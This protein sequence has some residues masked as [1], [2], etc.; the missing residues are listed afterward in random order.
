MS[1]SDLRQSLASVLEGWRVGEGLSKKDA[2]ARLGV[3]P[4][5]YADY[6]NGRIM[7]RPAVLRRIVEATGTDWYRWVSDDE[8]PQQLDQEIAQLREELH[9]RLDEL[10][11]ALSSRSAANPSPPSEKTP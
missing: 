9:K 3:S 10:E 8:R 1:P 4:R 7:P 2:A 11:A 6:A 5:S